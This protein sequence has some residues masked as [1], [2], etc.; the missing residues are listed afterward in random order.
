MYDPV[1][2]IGAEIN[3]NKVTM[4]FV[5][6]ERG[7]DDLTADGII[8]DQSGPGSITPNSS[9]GSSGGSG[10]FIGTAASGLFM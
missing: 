3:R 4:H 6:G 7:D 10:C 8:V 9:D 1:T 5:D 2:R